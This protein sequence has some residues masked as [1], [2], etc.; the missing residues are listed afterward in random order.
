[1]TDAPARLW[2]VRHGQTDWNI[3][4]RVQGHTP[5][6]LNAEGQRQAEALGR[7]LAGRRFAAIWT[8]DLPRAYQT[9]DLVAAAV[10]APVH[11]SPGLRE[12]SFGP[13]EGLTGAEVNAGRMAAGLPPT[14]DLTDWVGVPGVEGDDVVWARLSA[15]LRE[16]SGRYVGDDVLVVTH[17]GIVAR[18]VFHVLGIPADRPRRFSVANGI[19]AV[20]QWRGE[21]PH[22]LTLADMGLVTGGVAAADTAT[23][24]GPPAGA[25]A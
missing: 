18:A 9:A 10:G 20:L 14:N 8:S 17:G 24:A 1:M 13:Y 3:A 7:S 2:L 11:R 23:Q 6:E 25:G 5:T 16:L 12:R 19:V 4:G 15:T 22:L 21:V